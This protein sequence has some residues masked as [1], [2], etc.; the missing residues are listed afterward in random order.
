[1]PSYFTLA[2]SYDLFSAPEQKLAMLGSFQN[3]NFGGDNMTGGLE[4]SYRNT[5]AL[6]GSYFGSIISSTDPVTGEDNGDVK[7]GDDLYSGLAFGAGAKVKTGGTSSRWTSRI[8][9]CGTSSMTRSRSASSSTSDRGPNQAARRSDPPGRF[10][11][12]LV[13]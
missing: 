11:S 8:V 12:Y 5:F 10:I 2:A 6:R 3:N 9:R 7:G 13:V 4:W 1:M